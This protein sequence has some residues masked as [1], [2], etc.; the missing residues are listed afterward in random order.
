MKWFVVSAGLFMMGCSKPIKYQTSLQIN[1]DSLLKYHRNQLTEKKA[2]LTK[3]SNINGKKSSIKIPAEAIHWDTEF[4]SFKVLNSINKP[5]NSSAYSLQIK[6]DDKSNL[7]VKSWTTNRSLPLKQLKVYF[8]R[9]FKQIK[10]VEATIVQNNFIFNS[11]KEL[12]L[13]FSVLGAYPIA[14]DYKIEG[15]QKFFWE[16][17]QYFSLAGNILVK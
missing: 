6:N 16:E 5:I 13:N 7:I 1:I 12:N 2:Q 10:K 17:P 15:H 8:L 4:E 3:I 14:E 11:T 9:D